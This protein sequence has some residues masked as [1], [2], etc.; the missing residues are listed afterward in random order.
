M[1]HESGILMMSCIVYCVIAFQ[2]HLQIRWA[3]QHG[4][5]II[6]QESQTVMREVVIF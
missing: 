3:M 1:N 5:V 6:I 4:T 2:S